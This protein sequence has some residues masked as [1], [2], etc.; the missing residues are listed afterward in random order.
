MACQFKGKRKILDQQFKSSE[1]IRVLNYVNNIDINNW[2]RE[3]N[4][5][6]KKI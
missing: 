4:K 3:I 1:I 5:M 6:N 2:N